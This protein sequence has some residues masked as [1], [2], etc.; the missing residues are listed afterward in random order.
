MSFAARLI[1]GEDEHASTIIRTVAS[2]AEGLGL[3][4]VVEGIE[5]T[6]QLARLRGAR[7][8]VRPGL[9]VRQADAGQRGRSRT[10]RRAARPRERTAGR[11]SY[12]RFSVPALVTPPPVNS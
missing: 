8:P 11:L 1:D 6:D 9:P 3:D 5:T 2:L 7:L 12:L 4:F 10:R